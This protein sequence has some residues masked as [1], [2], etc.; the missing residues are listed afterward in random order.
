MKYKRSV[1][2]GFVHRIFR[3]CSTWSHFDESLQKAKKILEK[4]QYPKGFYEQIISKMLTTII[5]TNSGKMNNDDIPKENEQTKLLI[6]QY[7][8][9]L[10]EKF[11]QSLKRIN[12]PCK[13]VYT[14]KKLKSS[15]SVLKATVEKRFKS[16]VVYRICCPRCSACY[17][18]Q[19]SRHMITRLNEHRSTASVGKHFDECGIELSMDDVNFLC[20]MSRS[21]NY[22]MTLEALHIKDVKP[23]LNKKDEYKSRTLVI[24]I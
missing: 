12:A 1:I 11:E 8:G 13:V 22:L 17:V 15:V 2:I 3:A 7:R 16:R 21:T 23:T 18:G 10:S 20:S 4:N 5:E 9:K 6:L 19:T 24:K 14:M